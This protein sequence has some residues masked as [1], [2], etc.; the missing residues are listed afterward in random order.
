MSGTTSPAGAPRTSPTASPTA[1]SPGG[2]MPR[3]TTH[4]IS[5]GNTNPGGRGPRCGGHPPSRQPVHWSRFMNVVGQRELPRLDREV[6]G[7]TYRIP[8][9]GLK[10]EGGMV[11]CSVELP[12]FTLRYTTDGGEPTARSSLVRGP[13]PL[14]GTIR[15]AAF[16]TT[17][18][19]GHAAR[20]SAP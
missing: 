13:I 4:F 5:P 2:F 8:T 6:P 20:L 1:G 3:P 10:V 19:Q 15:V 7:V 9:P 12:G 18:R 16:N 14:R 11:H 17:D